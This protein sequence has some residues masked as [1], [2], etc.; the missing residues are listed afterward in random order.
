MKNFSLIGPAHKHRFI[1]R[2]SGVIGSQD[3]IKIAGY[4]EARHYRNSW[5]LEQRLYRK[6]WLAIGGKNIQK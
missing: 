4:S 3:Y 2:L 6:G 1:S 5:I